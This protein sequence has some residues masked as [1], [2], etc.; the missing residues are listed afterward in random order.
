M[1]FGSNPNA[2]DDFKKKTYCGM[3]ADVKCHR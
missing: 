3:Y 2:T 1:G